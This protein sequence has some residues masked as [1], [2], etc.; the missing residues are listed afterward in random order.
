MPLSNWSRRPET[1]DAASDTVPSSEHT[2]TRDRDCR[3]AHDDERQART[4]R[5]D[6]E[7]LPGDLPAWAIWEEQED[8]STEDYD[9]DPDDEKDRHA[10]SLRLHAPAVNHRPSTH[11]WRIAALVNVRRVGVTAGAE[12]SIGGSELACSP[13]STPPEGSRR[14][15][16]RPCSASSPSPPTL[17]FAS[18]VSA[19]SSSSA[20]STRFGVECSMYERRVG[21]RTRAQAEMVVAAE[22]A[23][24]WASWLAELLAP[25]VPEGRFPGSDR[26]RR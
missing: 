18:F 1:V 21:R 3:N 10:P 2:A 8:E 12:G 22:P 23:V 15:M 11:A 6:F 17:S 24:S 14:A 26:A 13:I 16:S 4:N 5:A 7:P 25:R 19:A 20:A 9:S